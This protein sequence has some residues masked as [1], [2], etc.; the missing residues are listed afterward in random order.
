MKKLFII[1]IISIIPLI[2]IADW[3][4]D[5]EKKFNRKMEK[6]T[7]KFDEHS[8]RLDEKFANTLKDDWFN[9]QFKKSK[10]LLK[11][12]KP[13]KIP[14]APVQPKPKEE[15]TPIVKLTSAA[16]V[17]EPVMKKAP[18][19][20]VPPP[21]RLPDNKYNI[22]FK[23]LSE[24]VTVTLPKK[25]KNVKLK[26]LDNKGI[27]G[28][29]EELCSLDHKTTFKQLKKYHEELLRN[30]WAFLMFIELMSKKVYSKSK[31]KQILYTW[32]L[33][34]KS[35]YMARIGY[36][37]RRV[38]LLLP[39]TTML[40]SQS[41][42][43]LDKTKFYKLSTQK[44][45]TRLGSIY[46]YPGKY[47]N[48]DKK[49]ELKIDQWPGVSR[50]IKSKRLSFTYKGKKYTIVVKYQGEVINFTKNYPQ[51][52]IGAYAAAP[53]SDLS[54]G[55]L[56]VEMAKLL[57]GKTETEAI[58][59]LL[60]FVQKSFAYKTDDKQFGHEK[61][62]FAEEILFYPYS[63]CEDRSVIFAR[64]VR[65]LLG[66]KVVLLQY[67]EHIATAVRFSKNVS[68]DKVRYKRETYAVCDPT[69]VNATYGMAMP[70]FKRVRPEVSE[71]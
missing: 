65:K 41:Y 48:A 40:Y 52:I 64:L 70:R 30:D 6:L 15:K 11:K 42:F 60:A 71:F 12:P 54:K 63:D 5:M 46:T 33:L 44:I 34:L 24:N 3:L 10:G 55:T 59:L 2:L 49:L 18:V 17:P 28:F 9:V 16:Q 8:R 21:S 14:K 51:T 26:T 47:P 38:Y 45:D 50:S 37:K 53:L 4:D 23:F 67:P 36:D 32:F 39:A 61:W 35:E 66:L 29:W 1:L 13:V 20:I 25:I 31:N 57:K 58:N 69:Y 19:I 43:T 7:D 68:G 56:L 22:K 62:F 27:A